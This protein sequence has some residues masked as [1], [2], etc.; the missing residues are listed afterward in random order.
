MIDLNKMFDKCRYPEEVLRVDE[1]YSNDI[2]VGYDKL[3]QKTLVVRGF[4]K[5]KIVKSTKNINVSL[6]KKDNNK[7]SLSFTLLDARYSTLFYKFCED[8]IANS[9]NIEKEKIIIHTIGRW[10]TWINMFENASNSGLGLLQIQGLMGELLFIKNYLM[11]EFGE[12]VAINSWTGPE[13]NHKDFY[14]KYK[15][16]EVK[17]IGLSKHSVLI[18]SIEQLDDEEIG[19]LVVNKLQKVSKEFYNT[20][21][22]NKLVFEITKLVHDPYLLESFNIKLKTL[23][24][25]YHKEYDD[26]NYIHKKTTFYKVDKEF[27]CLKRCNISKEILKANYELEL[28]DLVEERV[29][30]WK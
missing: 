28:T 24:Y 5:Q 22:L 8:I 11:K 17:T 12:E 25:T 23:G 2:Y 20:I 29:L 27:P 3:M 9:V 10:K 26:I 6:D 13:G 4:S 18:S 1:K 21:N 7:I 15:W 16:Y 30:L 19:F 14:C